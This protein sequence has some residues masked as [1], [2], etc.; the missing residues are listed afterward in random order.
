MPTPQKHIVKELQAIDKDLSVV[1]NK[2]ISRYMVYHKDK[3][4]RIYPVVKVQYGDGSF[5]PFD[6]R[7]VDAIKYSNRLRAKRP[8]EILYLIDK[9]NDDLERKKAKC[10]RNDAKSIASEIPHGE[11]ALREW[12]K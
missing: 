1:W 4:N 11:L 8:Q 3:H 5:K 7:T 2:R 12:S 9:E 6:K 10:M